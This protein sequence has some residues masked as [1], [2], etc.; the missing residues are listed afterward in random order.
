MILH[1]INRSLK[2]IDL[3]D[4]DYGTVTTTIYNFERFLTT[5]TQNGLFES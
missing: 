5:K 2:Y 1:I 3:M 4:R